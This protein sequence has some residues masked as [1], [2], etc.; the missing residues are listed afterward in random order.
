MSVFLNFVFAWEEKFFFRRKY[1]LVT[2]HLIG[3][4]EATT[5]WHCWHESP[6]PWGDWGCHWINWIAMAITFDHIQPS[7]NTGITASSEGLLLYLKNYLEFFKFW[8]SESLG[9]SSRT[10]NE[11]LFQLTRKLVH[12]QQGGQSFYIYKLKTITD[13]SF[14]IENYYNVEKYH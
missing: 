5:R 12:P 10:N 6:V 11:Q 9:N 8:S 3:T 7:N 2:N 4:C 14:C 1:A 13:L